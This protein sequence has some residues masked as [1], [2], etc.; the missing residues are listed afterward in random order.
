MPRRYGE[1]LK[2][3]S[4]TPGSHKVAPACEEA[5]IA[6]HQTRAF[7]GTGC[8]PEGCPERPEHFLHWKCR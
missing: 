1:V 7:Q 4:P 3:P 2:Q 5:E 6:P 8:C